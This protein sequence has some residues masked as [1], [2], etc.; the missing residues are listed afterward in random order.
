MLVGSIVD[1]VVSGVVMVLCVMLFIL[2]F[3]RLF[4]VGGVLPNT[5]TSVMA[6]TWRP[7]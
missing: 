3:H 6:H 1:T 4:C 5:T 2:L 7:Q